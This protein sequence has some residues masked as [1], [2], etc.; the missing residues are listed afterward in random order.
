MSSHPVLASWLR[1]KLN[2]IGDFSCRIWYLVKFS[3]NLRDS[4]GLKYCRT[5]RARNLW[6]PAGERLTSDD[7][8]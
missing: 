5:G 2:Y 3:N 7:D 4:V 6:E 8:L 1:A